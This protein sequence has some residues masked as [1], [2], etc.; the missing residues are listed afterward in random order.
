MI[1]KKGFDQFVKNSSKES[2]HTASMG[3]KSI[4]IKRQTKVLFP[5]KLVSKNMTF[6]IFLVTIRV[7]PLIF[8]RHLLK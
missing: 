7:K 8:V 4:L 2:D 1:Q 5:L 6:I 3:L